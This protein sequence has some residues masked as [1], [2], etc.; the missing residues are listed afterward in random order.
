MVLWILVRNR[1]RDSGNMAELV[2][3]M[4]QFDGGKGVS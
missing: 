2:S 4:P 3:L 1:V